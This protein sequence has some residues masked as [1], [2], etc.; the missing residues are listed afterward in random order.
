MMPSSLDPTRKVTSQIAHDLCSP[1]TTI[2]AV[3]NHCNQTGTLGK[4]FL[5]L[6][7]LSCKRLQGIV[8]DLLEDDSKNQKPFSLHSVLDELLEEYTAY[9]GNRIEFRKSFGTSAICLGDPGRIQRAF[10]NILKNA[11]EAIDGEGVITIST[12]VK[13]DKWIVIEISDT[14]GGMAP[15][16]LHLVLKGAGYTKGKETGHGIGMSVVRDVLEEHGGAIEGIS[17]I[18]KGTTW[19]VSLL[20][21]G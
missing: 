7:D 14:G 6:L 16:D 4:D 9:L 21:A 15:E 19:R 2:R 18:G 3:V 17:E 10:D 8:R 1:L 12:K 20:I 5:K 13:E 11:V